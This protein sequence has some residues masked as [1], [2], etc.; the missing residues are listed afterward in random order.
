MAALASVEVELQ[1]GDALVEQAGEHGVIG[2]CAAV[3]MNGS[4]H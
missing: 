1:R 4:R 2:G 3:P